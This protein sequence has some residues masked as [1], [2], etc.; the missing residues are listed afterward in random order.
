MFFPPAFSVSLGHHWKHEQAI[1]TQISHLSWLSVFFYT[2][3]YSSNFVLSFLMQEN[4]LKIIWTSFLNI[5]FARKGF[6]NASFAS[7]TIRIS[8]NAGFGAYI[9]KCLCRL[10]MAIAGQ[11]CSYFNNFS[12]ISFRILIILCYLC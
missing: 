11:A 3:S 2:M 5:C 1:K 7:S 6:P 8:V 12:H 9:S 10:F 4:S